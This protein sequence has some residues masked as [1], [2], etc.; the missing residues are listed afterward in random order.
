MRQRKLAQLQWLL[1]HDLMCE[2]CAGLGTVNHTSSWKL[3][4]YNLRM[5]VWHIK[6]N[7]WLSRNWG[8]VP[9]YEGVVTQGP[10]PRCQ[11]VS[12]RPIPTTELER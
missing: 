12:V 6:G 1:K 8:G 10:C 4:K 2:N 9:S 5:A 11:G 3:I 7:P